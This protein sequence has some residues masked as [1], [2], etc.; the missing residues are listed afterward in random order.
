M[1]LLHLDASVLNQNSSSRVL[2]ARIVE[3]LREIHRDLDV[4]YRDLASDVIPHLSGE[5]VLSRFVPSEQ[6]SQV[7]KD[8]DVLT[9]AL[10]KEFLEAD[11]VVIAAPMYN[12]SIP[13]QLKAWI[14]RVC[15]IGRT[16]HYTEAGPKGLA[17]GKTVYIGSSRGG[18]YTNEL[19]R[20]MDFQ[21][22][23]LKT[24]LGLFGITDITVVRAQGY[25]RDQVARLEALTV[26]GQE[27]DQLFAGAK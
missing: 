16:F 17:G 10:L 11:I 22:D 12:F 7:Q 5:I 2:T 23:Y 24:V 8:E 27:I 18:T 25:G 13:T 1:K 19:A 15:Q 20:L 3:K 9:E 21:E 4:V 26:A 14:D 6:W